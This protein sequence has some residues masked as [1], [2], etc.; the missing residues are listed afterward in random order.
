M[1]ITGHSHFTLLCF[2]A[3]EK[4][5]HFIFYD[6]WFKAVKCPWWY[7]DTFVT[8]IL[9]KWWCCPIYSSLWC[10]R[11]KSNDDTPWLNGSERDKQADSIWGKFTYGYLYKL[12]SRTTMCQCENATWLSSQGWQCHTLYIVASHEAVAIG[13]YNIMLA[14]LFYSIRATLVVVYY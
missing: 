1:K 8:A 5:L 3:A 4:K 14:V 12:V 7:R 10:M 13:R 9:Q 11:T 2:H 6:L